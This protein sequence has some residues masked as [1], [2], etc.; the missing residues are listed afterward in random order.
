MDNAREGISKTYLSVKEQEEFWREHAEARRKLDEEWAKLS[1]TE[2][3]RLH[4]KMKANHKAMRDATKQGL[5]I[6]EGGD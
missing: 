5:P 4:E 6:E 3:L 1:F 2:K